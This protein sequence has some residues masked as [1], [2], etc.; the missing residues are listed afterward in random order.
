MVEL[1]PWTDVVCMMAAAAPGVHVGT[2]LRA[3]GADAFRHRP[4]RRARAAYAASESIS[5][6]QAESASVGATKRSPRRSAAAA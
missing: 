3:V 4:A 5:S 6:A 1:S 2:W